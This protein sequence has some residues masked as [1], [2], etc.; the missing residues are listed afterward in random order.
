MRK[1]FKIYLERSDGFIG[2]RKGYMLNSNSLSFEEQNT[3]DDMTNKARFFGLS[4]E[5]SLPKG[6]ADY[7]KYKMTV[8]ENGKSDTIEINDFA[9]SPELR[10]LINYIMTKGKS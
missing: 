2:G 8:E 6:G 4:S 9:I 5:A 3:L 7:F 1:T 10:T